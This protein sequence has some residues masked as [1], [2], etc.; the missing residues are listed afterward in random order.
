MYLLHT[1]I[2][3][4]GKDLLTTMYHRD[5]DLQMTLIFII[6]LKQFVLK[7]RFSVITF[8]LVDRFTSYSHTMLFWSRP[9]H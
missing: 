6:V 3:C 9:L 7:C 1:H 5:L 2:Q 8:S 4:I